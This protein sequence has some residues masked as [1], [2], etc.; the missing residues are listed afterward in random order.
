MSIPTTEQGR[1]EG[2]TVADLQRIVTL[3]SL[4]ALQSNGYAKYVA[5]NQGKGFANFGPARGLQ[6][7]ID[8]NIA[9]IYANLDRL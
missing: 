9:E 4:R 3:W 6:A 7:N 8:T 5:A 2:K 1:K